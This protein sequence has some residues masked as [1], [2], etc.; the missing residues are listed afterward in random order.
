MVGDIFA[1]CDGHVRDRGVAGGVNKLEREL[2]LEL[3]LIE[4]WERAPSVGRL[5]LRRGITLLA[6]DRAIEAAQRLTDPTGPLD[7]ERV[8]ARR[9][10]LREAQDRDLRVRLET[11][12]LERDAVDICRRDVQLDRMEH[13]LAAGLLTRE[14][15][16]LPAR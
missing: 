10:L 9:D 7:L 11:R 12:V 13:D 3:G 4:A 15:D 14:G 5:E 2:C 1:G 6:A 8:V 16:A